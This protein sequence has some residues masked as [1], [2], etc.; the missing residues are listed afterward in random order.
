MNVSL[1]RV[2][3]EFCEGKMNSL[4]EYDEDNVNVNLPLVQLILNDMEYSKSEHK[5]DYT[6]DPYRKIGEGLSTKRYKSH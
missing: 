6:F 3:L 4:Y 2:Q 5:V 1:K